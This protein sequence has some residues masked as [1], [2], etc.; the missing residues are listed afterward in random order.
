MH[1]AGEA[2][3]RDFVRPKPTALHGLRNRHTTRTPP[4]LRM[5][6]RPPDFRRGKRSVLLRGG[7]DDVPLLVKDQG[8]SSARADVN[9]QYENVRPLSPTHRGAHDEVPHIKWPWEGEGT[10]RLASVPQFFKVVFQE[11]EAR[12]CKSHSTSSKRWRSHFC[13][14]ELLA[15]RAGPSC[16][17]KT[18][19]RCSA[20]SC[21]SLVAICS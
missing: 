3:A 17:W 7:G 10:A 19:L 6:L 21:S 4:V 14:C 2:D 16:I 8:A 1:L 11:F 20:S 18:I 9:P 5:L 13:G 12:G 15:S